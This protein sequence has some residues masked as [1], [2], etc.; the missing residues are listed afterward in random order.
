MEW[1]GLG[2]ARAAFSPAAEGCLLA[3]YQELRTKILYLE[4][5]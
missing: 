3:S 4:L 5:T 1:F 2:R